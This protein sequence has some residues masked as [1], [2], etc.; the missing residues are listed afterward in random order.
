M[1]NRII[2][3]NEAFYLEYFF[4]NFKVTTR[5]YTRKDYKLHWNSFVLILRLSYNSLEYVLRY[6]VSQICDS[7]N[8]SL[9]KF[10]QFSTE[11][12]NSH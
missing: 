3:K 10:F 4:V 8:E 7:Q 1:L 11:T 9:S 2:T 6:C 5:R 12:I